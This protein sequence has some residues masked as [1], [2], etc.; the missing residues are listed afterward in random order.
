MPPEDKPQGSQSQSGQG[1]GD[2]PKY[3]TEEQLNRAISARLG[4]F[5]KK[6]EKTLGESL[7]TMLGSKLEEFKASITPQADPS[8]EGSPK[9]ADIESHPFVKGLL[10]QMSDQKALTEQLKSERDAEKA[11]ARD[12]KLRTKLSDELTKH[13]LDPKYVRHA[14]GV[15]VDSEKRVRFAADDGDDLVFHEPAGAVD[16][17]TGLKGWVKSDDAKIYLPPRGTQGSGGQPGAKAPMNG[18]QQQTMSA[19][20]ALVGMALGFGNRGD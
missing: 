6:I 3:V 5:G 18:Q 7:G 13:G 10:K 20:K 19:G 12:Q 16:L 17:A 15:L 4:E 8:K 9:A 1:E 2:P 11:S 14:V